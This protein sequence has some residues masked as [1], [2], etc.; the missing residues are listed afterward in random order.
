[1]TLPLWNC[2]ASELHARV[3]AGA[4]SVEQIVAATLERI[5][6]REPDIHAWTWLDAEGALAA[7]HKQDHD[8]AR[9]SLSGVVVGLKDII[10]TADM[11]TT[12]GAA[13][14]RD[15]R[16]A[17]DAALVTRLRRAGAII[18]G[19]TV[20]TEFAYAAPGPTR[21]PHD[22]EH[23][24]GGSSSGSAAAVAAGM[25]GLAISSQ[26]G[27][28]TIRP[29]AFCGVVGFKPTHGLVDSSGMKALAPSSDTV[30][31]HARSV[32][33]IAL[34]FAELADQATSAHVRTPARIAWF[35]G[36]HALAAS[37]PAVAALEQLRRVLEKHGMQLATP[38][39]AP[40]DVAALGECNSLIMAVEGAHSLEPEYRLHREQLAAPTQRLIE[41][42][43]QVSVER[44]REALEFVEQRR[45]GFDA[46]MTIGG[47]DALL[48]FSAPG[49][50]PLAADGTGNSLFNRPW[51]ALGAPC[52]N[53]PCGF[54]AGL[55]LG[56][57]LVARCGADLALLELGGEIERCL[58]QDLSIAG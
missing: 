29:A 46:A 56:V 5:A 40:A 37:A 9:G 17:R 55:P 24:P 3:L 21:N 1:M 8:G 18:L 48:T 16:P 26:T 23:T 10:D 34:A 52:L 19:K 6:Q 41:T 4:C 49:I 13:L 31:L 45:A 12:Y 15:H 58:R 51:S 42:G 53:L 35:P 33:D 36:P 32:A 39:L 43:R 54:S 44:Y 2:S 7:A 57:Q 47:F 20:T 25:A 50:A 11:P 27:G 38:D 22:T 30:G 14:Y 28:S